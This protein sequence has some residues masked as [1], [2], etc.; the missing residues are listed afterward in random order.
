[1]SDH[2]DLLWLEDAIDH[3]LACRDSFLEDRA[4]TQTETVAVDRV[5]GRVIAEDVVA[6]A[7][8]PAADHAT[9]DGYAF[10]AEDEGPL[11]V[12]DA[13][14]YPETEP[15]TLEAGRAI[16][17]ATGAPLPKRADTVVKR[18]DTSVVDDRLEKPDLDAGTY[19]YERGSNVAAG[20][21]LYAAG[22]RLSA[23]DAILLR[24]V[25]REEVAVAEPFSVAVLA[26]GTEIHEGRHT[27]LDSPMLCNLVRG[28]GHE[29]TY[30]GSVP[31]EDD[32]VEDRI[33]DLAEA[34]DVV[35]TTGGTSVGKKDYVLDALASLGEV[36]FHRV[37]IRPGKPIAI[38]RLPAYDAL[39]VAVPGKPIG[40]YVSTTLVARPLFTGEAS[41]PS[42][43]RT[44][45]Q[46]VGLGPSGFTYA[47]PVTLDGDD[48]TPLGHASSPLSVYEE[49][50]DP[51]VLSSSTRAAAADGF[52]LTTE[53]LAAG[54]RVDVVPTTA[55]E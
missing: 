29:P 41:P 23:L 40:A 48:A 1:M 54:E 39:A 35:V 18:E 17:I 8:Q 44:F 10:A 6:E 36:T 14:I 45:T 26:T 24:D 49:T 21:R 3:A 43:E 46:D 9:M 34:N 52:V 33:A 25:G 47:I 50:F 13:D 20:D 30:E 28:W 38:A 4:Q 5:A 55:L 51:S 22:D 11:E 15:P 16:E 12:V 19:V 7:D 2:D 37:R 31:D 42:L 53:G 27:D 32:R